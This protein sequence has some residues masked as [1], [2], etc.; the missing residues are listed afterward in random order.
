MKVTCGC[1]FCNFIG[2][3]SADIE[4]WQVN[5]GNTDR[6]VNARKSYLHFCHFAGEAILCS[7]FLYFPLIFRFS[8]FYKIKVL[9][10]ETWDKLHLVSFQITFHNRQKTQF[11]PK[12]QLRPSCIHMTT[13]DADRVDDEY[14]ESVW[15][16]SLVSWLVIFWQL[17]LLML[18]V[19]EPSCNF[20]SRNFAFRLIRYSC[21]FSRLCLPIWPTCRFVTKS[22]NHAQGIRTDQFL[23][24]T[25]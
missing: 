18:L 4:A 15:L 11:R 12:C 3:I 5:L 14:K 19:V 6:H 1:I 17:S 10:I 22:I 8:F 7:N 13:D 9:W 2:K 25:R 24:R 23:K 16:L 21:L 20:Y